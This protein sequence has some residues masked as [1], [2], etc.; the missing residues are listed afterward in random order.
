ME[1]KDYARSFD[2]A[3]MGRSGAAPLQEKPKTGGAS[4]SPTKETREGRLVSG[5]LFFGDDGVDVD[6]QGLGYASAVGWI[7]F[8]EM[9]DLE[10]LDVARDSVA[11]AAG[12]IVDEALFCIGGHQ[13]EE[14]TGLRVVVAVGTVIVTRN[15]AA[16][17]SWAFRVVLV[18]RWAAETIWFVVYGRAAI[19]IEAHGAVAMIRGVRAL[20]LVDRERIV[21]NAEAVAVRVGIGN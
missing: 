9:L 19:A 16:D 13:A 4:P 10:F 7:G 2:L 11:E 18:L 5:G 8:V 20:R 14:I 15:C 3:D 6:A 1:R 21:V 12:N 17:R